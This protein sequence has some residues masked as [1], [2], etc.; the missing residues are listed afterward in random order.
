[1][2]RKS[3]LLDT[4]VIVYAL[5]L[6]SILG[7]VIYSARYILFRPWTARRWVSAGAGGGEG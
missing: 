5:I 2:K 3:T 7:V 4:Q 6:L 1:M